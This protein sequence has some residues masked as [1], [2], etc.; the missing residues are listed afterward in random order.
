MLLAD[1]YVLHAILFLLLTKTLQLQEFKR[2]FLSS[3]PGQPFLK[4]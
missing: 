1:F 4:R 2:K 3:Q